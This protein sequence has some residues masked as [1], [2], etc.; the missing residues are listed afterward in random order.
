MELVYHDLARMDEI[1][2]F[3]QQWE[4]SSDYIQCQTSGSTGTPKSIQLSKKMMAHSA[5]RTLDFFNL[6]TGMKAGLALSIQTIGGKMMLLRA[7]MARLELHVLPVNKNPLL[8]VAVELDFIPLVP[9]QAINYLNQNKA[10]GRQKN[11]TLLLGGSDISQNQQFEITAYWSKVYQSYG[12]TETASH[13][14]IRKLDNT[15]NNPYSALDGFSFSVNQGCLNIHSKDLEETIQTNDQVQLLDAQTFHYMGRTDFVI[16]S[17]GKKFHPE[18]IEYELSSILDE[19]F[20]IAPY[21]D[22]NYGQGLGI[23]WTGNSEIRRET[24]LQKGIS[25]ELVPRKIIRLK[26]LIKT[27]SGKTHRLAMIQ[28]ISTHVWEP[29]L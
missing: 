22:E 7:I 16:N 28:E 18:A 6:S 26:G 1:K 25:Q 9:L 13:V 8:N 27:S 29:I 10:L 15:I 24:F 5:Q 2:E 11:T 17:G 19:E 21:P 23:V 4:N 20:M 12:M 14:A 3:I